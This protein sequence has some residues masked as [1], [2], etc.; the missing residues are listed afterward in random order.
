MTRESRTLA[1]ILLVILPTVMIGGASLLRFLIT[2]APGYMDNPI[3]QDLFRAGHAHAGVYLVLALVLLRYVDEAELSESW[4]RFTRVAAPLAAILVPAAFFLSV[5]SPSATE[6][7]ALIYLA[8]VGGLILAT[9]VVALGVG[10]LRSAK[11]S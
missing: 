1:G 7:N 6:P 11:R 2:R 8:Y 4:K 9:G 3:R 5:A 10:V